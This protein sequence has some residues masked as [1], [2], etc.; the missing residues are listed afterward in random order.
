[1]VVLKALDSYVICIAIS[2]TFHTVYNERQLSL[3]QMRVIKLPLAS[4]LLSVLP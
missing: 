3:P 4:S 2:Q 1:M